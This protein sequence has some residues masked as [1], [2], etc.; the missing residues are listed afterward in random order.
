MNRYNM[1]K[2]KI[3]E[4]FFNSSSN[5][6]KRILFLNL[7]IL[8]IFF[9]PLVSSSKK[10][11]ARNASNE[12]FLV[13]NISTGQNYFG[14]NETKK[15]Y[16]ASITKIATAIL[17]IEKLPLDKK[18]N[19]TK[20]VSTIPIDYVLTPLDPKKTYTVRDLLYSSLLK[21]ANDSTIVLATALFKDNKTFEKEINLFLQSIGCKNTHFNSSYG[22]HS[23]NHY[24]TL[25][26][27]ATLAKYALKNDTF[28]R[29]VSSKKYTLNDG[30]TVYSTSLFYS[31]DKSIQSDLF[32][33]IKTGYTEQAGHCFIT[34]SNI[35][36][37]D[38]ILISTGERDR[39]NCF[40]KI[41]HAR[42]DLEQSIQK[43]KNILNIITSEETIYSKNLYS[44]KNIIDM[45]YLSLISVFFF[46]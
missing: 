1:S 28:K 40:K 10:A 34:S 45:F 36:G 20:N 21:S 19:V 4:Y 16:P 42:N 3:S 15:I 33:G 14:E 12:A 8:F 30:N 24:T 6:L 38:Y 5:D 41:L 18:L 37:E 25:E 7:F 11:Y 32:L 2:Q 13:Q 44:L 29:I 27:L 9:I 17:A 22:K 46:K 39:T 35:C 31:G 43:E 26:D 23:K